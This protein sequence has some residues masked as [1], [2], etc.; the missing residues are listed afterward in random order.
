MKLKVLSVVK[1]RSI[2]KCEIN[3]NDITAIVGQNNSGKSSI[4]RALNAFFNPLLELDSFIDKSHQYSKNTKTIIECTFS[5]VPDKNPF[6]SFTNRNGDL[7]VKLTFDN[8]KNLLIHNVRNS[9]NYKEA[10]KNF[11]NSL[12][13][14]I[15]YVLI[16]AIR[17]YEQTIA[18]KKTILKNLLDKYLNIY[19]AKRDTFS[20]PVTDAV[21]NL[22][23]NAL[24]KVSS[25]LNEN[26]NSKHE[27]NFSIQ[28]ISELNYEILLNDLTLN[29]EESNKLFK[30]ID[31]GSGV[32]SLANIAIYRLFAKLDK[33]KIILGIEEPEI[34]LHPQA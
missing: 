21:K 9:G 10:S 18:N 4:L 17:N 29:I 13:S 1:F 27:F 22:H 3:F 34:N 31:C 20:R 19:T 32:Q 7:T 12:F 8:K 5:D 16:P 6:K 11:I 15:G 14:E 23:N 25:E 30:L 24:K 26:Y 2:K 33:K 28:H